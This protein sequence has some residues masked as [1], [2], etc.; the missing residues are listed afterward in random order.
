MKAIPC[1]QVMKRTA[2]FIE[3]VMNTKKAINVTAAIIQKDGQFLCAQRKDSS[4]QGGKWEFPGG[5]I[6]NGESP[7]TCLEREL[8]E[9]FG[10]E[11][12]CADFFYENIHDYE[13]KIVNL[14][15][16]FVQHTRG[17]FQLLAHQNIKWLPL[18]EIHKLDWADA[19]L[20]IVKQLINYFK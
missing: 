10:I 7:E 15:S 9:E 5:K 2:K 16:Y 13:D 3:N 11:T 19:D 18:N 6:E 20:P 17:N 12:N 4:E 8:S 1:K 14:K